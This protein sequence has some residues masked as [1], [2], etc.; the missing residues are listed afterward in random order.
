M[1]RKRVF[2]SLLGPGEEASLFLITGNLA[3]SDW[4]QIL[5]SSKANDQQLADLFNAKNV[6]YDVRG[7]VC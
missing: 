4:G 1:S 3:Y 5:R 7:F 2:L 6:A